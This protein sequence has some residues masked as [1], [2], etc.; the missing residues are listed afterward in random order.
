MSMAGTTRA[1]DARAGY[2]VGFTPASIRLFAERAGVSKAHQWIDM[3]D[4]ERALRDD[5]DAVAAGG[6]CS[7]RW[8]GHRELSRRAI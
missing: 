6:R 2:V 1:L 5:L 7:I 8:R 4:L 3:G